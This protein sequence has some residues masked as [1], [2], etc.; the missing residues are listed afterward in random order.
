MEGSVGAPSGSGALQE[1]TP[2]PHHDR[3]P[4]GAPARWGGP[5]RDLGTGLFRFRFGFRAEWGTSAFRE[6]QGL[7]DRGGEEVEVA[8]GGFCL[9]GF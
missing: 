5:I 8:G 7:A 3:D 2:A 1:V 6:F 4:A 9:A